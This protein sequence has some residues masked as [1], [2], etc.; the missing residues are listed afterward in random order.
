M[1]GKKTYVQIFAIAFS[2]EV[3]TGFYVKI[4]LLCYIADF[5][6]ISCLLIFRSYGQFG[7]VPLYRK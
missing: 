5:F 3:L 4:L 1:F 7:P 6:L 2:S